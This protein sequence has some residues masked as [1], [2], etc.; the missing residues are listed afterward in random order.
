MRGRHHQAIAV[1]QSWMHLHINSCEDHRFQWYG[2]EHTLEN[3]H[4]LTHEPTNT[5]DPTLVCDSNI[6]FPSFM[7]YYHGH[8]HTNMRLA[9]AECKPSGRANTAHAVNRCYKCFIWW[10]SRVNVGLKTGQRHKQSF[11]Q[12]TRAYATHDASTRTGHDMQIFAFN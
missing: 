10:I 1:N 2:N 9:L 3:G 4:N 7:D 6:T 5:R 8:T 12:A 11:G